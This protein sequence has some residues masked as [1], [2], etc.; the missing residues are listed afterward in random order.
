MA[1]TPGLFIRQ[2]DVEFDVREDGS[3]RI[4]IA[5]QH[6]ELTGAQLRL[7]LQLLQAAS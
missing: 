4:G 2:G 5:G 6:V 3:V 7:L 1:L